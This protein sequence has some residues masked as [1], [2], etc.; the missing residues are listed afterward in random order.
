MGKFRGNSS[1]LKEVIHPVLKKPIF[2]P[3]D[4]EFYGNGAEKEKF[5]RTVQW[6]GKVSDWSGGRSE[7]D[8]ALDAF[9]G[10][11]VLAMVYLDFGYKLI[12]IEENPVLFSALKKNTLGAAKGKTRIGVH[13]RDNMDLLPKFRSDD[14]RIKIIDLD[15][16]NSCVL[17]IRQAARILKSG[18]LFVTAGDIYAGA[19]FKNWKFTKER[20]GIDFFGPPEDYPKNVIF[21]FIKDKFKRYGKQA[22][23]RDYFSFPT[24]CRLCVQIKSSKKETGDEEDGQSFYIQP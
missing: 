19:R 9:A 13:Q 20:Y 12:A 16:Y 2:V 23:L 11:G 7:G 18:F 17:Q 1:E 3:F 21:Q 5:K 15:S 24:I 14:S 4:F 8:T 22:E 6:L 10:A